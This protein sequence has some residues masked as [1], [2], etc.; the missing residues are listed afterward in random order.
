[1]DVKRQLKIAVT[2]GEVSVGCSQTLKALKT[3]KAKL[4]V[5][6]SKYPERLGGEILNIV[7]NFK[8][9][10]YMFDGDGR[11]LGATAGKPFPVSAL[12]IRSPG[13]SEILNLVER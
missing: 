9:P 2:T 1:M 13:E 8:V 3:G 11:Q 4:I 12:A 10:I 7:K 6:S 5:L